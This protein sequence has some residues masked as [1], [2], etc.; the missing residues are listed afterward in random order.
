MTDLVQLE[1]SL[2]KHEGVRERLYICPAG[3]L[4]IGVGHNLEAIPLTGLELRTL[5]DAGEITITLTQA[6]ISRVLKTDME[7]H[8]ELCQ[9]YFEH[10]EGLN[11]V[12]QNA[13]AEL[14]FQVGIN[15]L[16]KFK[17]FLAAVGVENW[18][19][20]KAE[21]VDS[22]WAKQTQPSRVKYITDLIETGEW[23]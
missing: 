23:P 1:T 10:W 13:I 8:I 6:G 19:K 21:L 9:N 2:R 20:A 11:D 12:R 22:R 7:D 3:K 15:G 14:C 5:Y 4:S 16:L 17:R 18:G